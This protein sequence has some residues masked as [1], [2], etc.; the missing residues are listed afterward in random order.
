MSGLGTERCAA[1]RA[2]LKLR[3]PATEAHRPECEVSERHLPLTRPFN[4]LRRQQNQ[5][6]HGF[7]HLMFRQDQFRDFT[8]YGKPG[9]QPVVALCLVKGFEQLA[10]LNSH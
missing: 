2:A 6:E 5:P 8:D 3:Q 9:A 1:V 10:L 7:R 4:L